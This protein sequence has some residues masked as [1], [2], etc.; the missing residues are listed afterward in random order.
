MATD[1]ENPGSEGEELIAAL[2]SLGGVKNV[3]GYGA[4][5]DGSTDDTAAIQAAVDYATSPYSSTYRGVIY[6]PPGTYRVTSSVTFERSTGINRIHFLGSGGAKIVGNFADAL[7][8]RD[9]D[10]ISGPD[11]TTIS[12][13]DL[14]LENEHTTG[15]AIALHCCIGAKV[16][17]CMIV[18]HIGVET[19]NGQAT[20]VDSCSFNR[21]DKT[22]AA[23]IG[24]LAG[25][26]TTVINSDFVSYEHG[27]RHHNVGLNVIGGRFEVNSTGIALGLDEDGAVFQSSNVFISGVSMETNLTAIYVGAVAGLQI[28]GGGCGVGTNETCDYGL[29]INGGN[30]ICVS[31]FIASESNIPYTESG[32]HVENGTTARITFISVVSPSWSVD[33]LQSG[34]FIN[35]NQGLLTFSNLPTAPVAGTIIAIGDGAATAIGAEVTSGGSTNDYVLCR[36]ASAWVRIA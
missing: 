6:F 25:N 8:R 1:I 3:K 30:D 33:A 13:R 16:T 9:P 23:S 4:V 36:G 10:A 15:K 19:W 21:S 5:G 12:I 27:I 14:F 34:Q 26:G 17:N 11:Y 7:L 18:A 28:S 24:V 2:A 20:T 22:L 29:R 35:C 31:G 32:I